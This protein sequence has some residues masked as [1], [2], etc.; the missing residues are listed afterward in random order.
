MRIRA[1]DHHAG[2]HESG[3]GEQGVLDAHA[4]EF[5]V[6]GDLVAPRELAQHLALLRGL[7]VLVGRK[8][9]RDKNHLVAVEDLRRPGPFELLDRQRRRDVVRQRDV[10]RHADNL[11]RAHGRQAGFRRQNLF[12]DGHAHATAPVAEFS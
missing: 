12:G 2:T 10:D 6:V 11:P 7:D 9:V 1:H 5:E 8:M 3:L 4:P